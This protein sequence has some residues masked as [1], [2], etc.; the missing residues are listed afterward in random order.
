MMIIDFNS[1]SS[2]LS[3]LESPV[4]APQEE[5]GSIKGME[6][7]DPS[8]CFGL[9]LGCSRGPSCMLNL[10]V[11]GWQ[12]VLGVGL[13][14]AGQLPQP[15]AQ[16]SGRGWWALSRAGGGMGEGCPLPPAS[17]PQLP[18]GAEPH[19]GVM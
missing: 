15:V 3:F 2:S 14:R 12:W 5:L 1:S 11:W 8:G 17:S 18:P 16:G 9:C 19:A 13:T 7:S 4:H 10:H 6:G